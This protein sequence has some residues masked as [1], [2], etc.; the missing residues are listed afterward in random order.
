MDTNRIPVSAIGTFQSEDPVF[1]QFGEATVSLKRKISYQ[2]I[3]DLVQLVVDFSITDQPILSGVIKNITLDMAIIKYYT[4]LECSIFEEGTALEQIYEEYGV[5]VDFGVIDE[6]KAKMDFNQKSFIEKTVAE[7]LSS[8]IDYRNSAKGIIDSL[9]SSAADDSG[10][11][12]SALDMFSGENGERLA[13]LI[14][15]SHEIAAPAQ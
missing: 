13:S 4:N 6:V 14:Q 11:M 7:T 9:A 5:L 3:L 10:K 8:I 12:Q 2:E 15:F 1:I